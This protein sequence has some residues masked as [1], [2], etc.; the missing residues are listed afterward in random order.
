MRRRAWTVVILALVLGACADPERPLVREGDDPG[1]DAGSTGFLGVDA[2]P[3]RVPDCGGSEA[4]LT[5]RRATAVLVID[6]SGSMA[7]NTVDATATS[8]WTALLAALRAV[9]LQVDQ[10]VE[11]GLALF[12]AAQPPG[13]NPQEMSCRV[14][15]ALTVE[16]RYGA[17]SAILDALA[18][19][20]PAGSTPTSGGLQL[21]FSWYLRAPDRDGERYVILA[22]DGGPNCGVDHDPRTCRCTGPRDPRLSP[23][24]RCNSTLSC[25]DETRPVTLIAEGARGGVPTY[26]LGLNGTEDFVDVLDAMASAGGRAR[27][28]APRYYPV[29]SAQALADQFQAITS[30]IAECRFALGSP[31][32][33]PDLV[34]VRLD[35]ASILRDARH[36]DGWDWSPAD[37]LEIR[38]YGRSCAILQAASGGS[39]LRAV[40][41]CAAPT[42]P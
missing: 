41:G 16:P 30:R 38:F 29:A 40:F 25:L 34:D 33:D 26:V 15:A 36:A 19:V 17:A 1:L 3:V 28:G 37:P 23:D 24:V 4:V 12:P 9:L 31:P 18:R 8:K 22:T 35:G 6:R 5:R 11:L 21:A 32:P 39:R 20:T 10:A 2:I 14:D 7:D 13:P 42:P 27:E